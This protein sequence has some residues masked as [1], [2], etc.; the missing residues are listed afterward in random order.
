[1]RG[2][3]TGEFWS[4]LIGA[5]V[6]LVVQYINANLNTFMDNK[7]GIVNSSFNVFRYGFYSTLSS[8]ILGAVLYK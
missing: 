2:D 1:M 6:G 7:F 5:G 4:I 3:Y 8:T